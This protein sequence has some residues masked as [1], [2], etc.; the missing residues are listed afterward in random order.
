MNS[1]SDREDDVKSVKLLKPYN[2]FITNQYRYQI[3]DIDRH[4]LNIKKGSES[5]F[6][7]PD[8]MVISQFEVH[9]DPNRGV[10]K[11]ASLSIFLLFV[12]KG[13]K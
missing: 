6:L 1:N 12:E 4:V 9:F 5:E 7:S 8:K 2:I 3:I 10:I 11:G 13:K